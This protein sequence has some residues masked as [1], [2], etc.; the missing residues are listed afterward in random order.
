MST[1]RGVMVAL[2]CIV[3]TS[4]QGLAIKNFVCN[5]W[6]LEPLEL[7]NGLDHGSYHPST[8]S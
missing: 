5:D 8:D 2:P 7:P 1:S 3:R 6:D 4:R